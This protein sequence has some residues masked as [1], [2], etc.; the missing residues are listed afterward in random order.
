MTALKTI[1][2][3][4]LVTVKTRLLVNVVTKID[5]SE[6]P[7]NKSWPPKA[8]KLTRH[9]FKSDDEANHDN[10]LHGEEARDQKKSSPE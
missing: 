10:S 9:C 3:N 1:S 7:V 4:M 5:R 8:K 2:A 6:R